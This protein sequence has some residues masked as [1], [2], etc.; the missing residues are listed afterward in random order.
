MATVTLIRAAAQTADGIYLMTAMPMNVNLGHLSGGA[1]QF[2]C[3][4]PFNQIR[5]ARSV[6]VT[7]DAAHGSW[8]EEIQ[9]SSVLP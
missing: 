5:G 8:H 2:G 7:Y 6:M 9:V 3:D 4:N 1:I